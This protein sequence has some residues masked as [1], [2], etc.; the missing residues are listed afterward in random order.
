MLHSNLGSPYYRDNSGR[1][2]FE[3]YQ[4]PQA[5]GGSF[6]NAPLYQPF[7]HPRD[8]V[9]D[10]AC[11]SGELLSLLRA[12]R[13]IGVEVNPSALEA[14]RA[15]GLEIFERL[16]EVPSGTIDVVISN[17]GLE[18]TLRPFDV[19][20]E[21]RRCARAGGRLVL[22]LPADAWWRQPSARSCDPNHH[23]YTWTPLLLAN[24]LGEAGWDVQYAKL[25][26][27][28]WPSRGYANLRHL[29]VGLAQAV[30]RACGLLLL[31]PQ[32]HA[33]ALNS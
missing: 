8:A 29:P 28:A 24:L 32:I 4:D 21:L 27:H 33:Y 20:S 7:V 15:R 3:T 25:K 6:L 10:F 23:L 1:S 18:H 14:A 17:H 30:C 11:G 19:L 2:Y 31:Q 16:E 22:Y 9:L 13:K 26:F 12:Q 5:R